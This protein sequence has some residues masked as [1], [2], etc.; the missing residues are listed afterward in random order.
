MLGLTGRCLCVHSSLRSFGH[1]EGGPETVVGALLDEGCTVMV[2]AFSYAFA[3]QP[4]PPRLRFG[5]NGTDY[6]EDLP[7]RDPGGR[8]YTPDTIEIDRAKMGAIPDAVV[9]MTGRIRGNHPLSSFAAIGPDAR[10]LLADQAPLDLYPP[11]RALADLD[12]LVVLM[13]V[14]LNRMTMLHHAER[15]AGRN[16]FRRWAL[17]H[18]RNIVAV[19]VGGCSDGFMNFTTLLAPIER[20]ARVGGSRWRV[21]PAATA[22]EIAT[23]AI[24]SDPAITHCED[25]HCLRCEHSV[26]GGVILTGE[27]GV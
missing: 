27:S 16:Q 14:G 19:E 10:R 12:G 7:P 2:P 6:G 11:F 26:A 23:E 5:R 21:F 4:P 1:V 24:R 8:V 3:V 13:G 15:L 22:L 18:G 25:E 9:R 17:D 20:E